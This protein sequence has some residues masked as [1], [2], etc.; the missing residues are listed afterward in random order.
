MYRAAPPPTSGS[1]DAPDARQPASR[2]L[3]HGQAKPFL[4]R[5]EQEYVASL[6]KDRQTLLRNVTEE[7]HSQ[8]KLLLADEFVNGF[9]AVPIATRENHPEM[10]R[11]LIRRPQRVQDILTR[12]QHADARH[13]GVIAPP[14][15]RAPKRARQAS[16]SRPEDPRPPATRT[17]SFGETWPSRSRLRWAARH[18]ER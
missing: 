5:R 1:E 10:R 3:E 11:E 6:T 2:G 15:A 18:H 17:R 8:P 4:E 13:Y 16:T 9:A 7:R 12:L 14:L